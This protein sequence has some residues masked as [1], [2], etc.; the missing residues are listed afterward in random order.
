MAK[1]H[2]SLPKMLAFLKA[3]KMTDV[4]LSAEGKLIK[5]HKLILALSSQYFEELFTTLTDNH[6][7]IVLKDVSFRNL[8]LILEF[9]YTGSVDLTPD[10]VKEFKRVADSLRIKVD[11]VVSEQDKETEQTSSDSDDD[12][13]A[14]VP[15][16]KFEKLVR[17]RKRLTRASISHESYANVEDMTSI[18]PKCSKITYSSKGSTS[19]TMTTKS[20]RTWIS[21]EEFEPPSKMLKTKSSAENDIMLKH[22]NTVTT[23]STKGVKCVHC[24]RRFASK[25]KSII[26]HQRYCWKNVERTE[27]NCKFCH[28]KYERPWS[29]LKHLKTYHSGTA[30]K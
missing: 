8:L 4:T 24:G 19:K 11:F 2:Q 7:V 21:D 20:M 1:V 12:A 25:N 17:K 10:D 5:A 16:T 26:N 3:E 28:K 13:G 18:Q 30:D 9:S 23:G 22:K 6:P 27:S 14:E 29:L 15:V